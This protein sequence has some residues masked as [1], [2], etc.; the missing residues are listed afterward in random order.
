MASL[1]KIGKRALV[2]VKIVVSVGILAYF[3]THIDYG[4]L[5]DILS[6]IDPLYLFPLVLLIVFRQVN[7]A[8]RFKWLIS[9]RLRVRFPVLFKQYFI[10][11]FF[12]TFLPTVLG[13]DG[14]RVFMLGDCGLSKSEAVSFILI[15]RLTGFF[16]YILISF[17]ASFFVS[18]PLQL[19]LIIYV[20]TACYILVY[21]L[22]FVFA[23]RLRNREFKLN[24]FKKLVDAFVMLQGNLGILAVTLGASVI[25]QLAAI[26]SA[27]LVSRAFNIQVQ[28]VLFLV[29]MPLIGLFMMIPISL[30]GV[31]LREASFVYFFSLY[32]IPR[33]DSLIISLGTYLVLVTG[34]ILGSLFFIYDKIFL[35]V[36]LRPA[37]PA[38]RNQTRR[39]VQDA[40]KSR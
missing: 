9:T 17:F 3:F 6:N 2:V 34:G 36:N 35:K 29:Y 26:A 40:D 37:K 27:V 38:A 11:G 7:A 20:V 31:G 1:E 15:E 33:E 24:I 23:Y 39:I 4:K 16:S 12:N 18:V 21:I 22:L 13:G 19:R 25:F 32:G 30:G 28:I 8:Y 5:S 10:A 14:V